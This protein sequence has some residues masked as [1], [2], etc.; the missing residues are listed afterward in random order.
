M[1]VRGLD[2]IDRDF[3]MAFSFKKRFD[4]FRYAFI[5][6]RESMAVDNEPTHIF[7]VRYEKPRFLVTH[8]PDFNEPLSCVS[9]HIEIPILLVSLVAKVNLNGQCSNRLINFL[10]CW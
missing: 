10:Q 8:Y 4:R 9:V 1:V 2:W 3:L 7:A 5:D 6:L